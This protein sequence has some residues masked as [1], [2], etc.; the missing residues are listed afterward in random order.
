MYGVLGLID[1]KKIK[2]VDFSVALKMYGFN[3]R[4]QEITYRAKI[5][6]ELHFIDLLLSKPVLV[7]EADDYI[8]L[9]EKRDFLRK[10]VERLSEGVFCPE[11]P[12]GIRQVEET[13]QNGGRYVRIRSLWD[14]L[15]VLHLSSVSDSPP[16]W[17]EVYYLPDEEAHKSSN[18]S[19]FD[20]S[21]RG[22]EF[23]MTED[24]Y[25]VE[26]VGRWVMVE[27]CCDSY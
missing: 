10:I 15:H 16:I 19:Y 4:L 23:I 13:S 18:R 24:I 22:R 12:G 5:Q 17:R 11:P 20:Y 2:R 14:L 1:E 6:M 25:F 7:K 9:L 3:Y 27:S 8:K 21:E 26:D